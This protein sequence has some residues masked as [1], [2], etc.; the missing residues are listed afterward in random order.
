MIATDIDFGIALVLDDL[1]PD[2]TVPKVREHLCDSAKGESRQVTD[3]EY[4]VYES[5]W[6]T[7][8]LMKGEVKIAPPLTAPPN[9]SQIGGAKW[10][11]FCCRGS[12]GRVGMGDIESA[13]RVDPTPTADPCGVPPSLNGLIAFLSRQ[14]GGSVYDWELVEITGAGIVTR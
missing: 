12:S 10:W 5:E 7:L 14:C 3:W 2:V 4:V 11:L 13:A 1:A 9:P 8:Q 6:M